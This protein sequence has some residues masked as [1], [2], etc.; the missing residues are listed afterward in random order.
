MRGEKG[1]LLPDFMNIGKVIGTIVATRKDEKLTGCKLLIT[2]PVDFK[3]T[4]IG[5][6][7]IAVD[8]VG[9]GI[10]E[11][12]IYTASGNA[13]RLSTRKLDAPIDAAIIG[14]V[15]RVDIE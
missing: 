10:G 8:T 7:F 9:A 14:I 4:P 2:Q 15:D 5:N 6:P 13:A 11:V 1:V 3:Y 12:V